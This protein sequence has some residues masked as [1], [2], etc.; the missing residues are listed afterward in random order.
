VYAATKTAVPVISGLRQEVKRWNLRTTIISPRAVA[1]E[2]PTSITEAD[3]ATGIGKF[4]EQLPR[5]P[6]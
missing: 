6:R 5:W 4:Y 3:I 1:T 2:L